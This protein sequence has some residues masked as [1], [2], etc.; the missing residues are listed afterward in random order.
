MHNMFWRGG[1]CTSQCSIHLCWT[2]RMVMQL[3]FLQE[4]TIIVHSMLQQGHK[5]YQGDV[6]EPGVW[7]GE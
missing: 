6:R 3:W 1:G 2:V 4:R 5:V 7:R